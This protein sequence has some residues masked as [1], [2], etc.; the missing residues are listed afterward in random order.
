M[1]RLQ[2]FIGIMLFYA[3][4]SCVIGPVFG[5]YI[6]GHSLETAG[7]GFICGSLVS[8]GLWLS[9]GKKMALK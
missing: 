7:T 8:I 6:G 4:L 3:I 5:Y 2:T 9:V 1:T